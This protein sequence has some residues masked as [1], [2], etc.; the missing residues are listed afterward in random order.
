MHT[1]RLRTRAPA[2]RSMSVDAAGKF[3]LTEAMT[4]SFPQLFKEAAPTK[5]ELAAIGRVIAA[6]FR[7]R[8][9]GKKPD[10]VNGGKTVQVDPIT[11]ESKGFSVYWYTGAQVNDLLAPVIAD[12]LQKLVAT[13]LCE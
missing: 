4:S 5:P 9:G 1:D 3:T 12:E 7:T 10:E 11:K 6:A 2:P 8:Y 13:L